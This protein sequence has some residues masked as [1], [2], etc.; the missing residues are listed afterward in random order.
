MAAQGLRA[1]SESHSL[2]FFL[3]FDLDPAVHFIHPNQSYRPLIDVK[4]T[5]KPL[6]FGSCI[7]ISH[8]YRICINSRDPLNREDRDLS[9]SRS[10][11]SAVI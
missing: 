2:T 3:F 8:N 5:T 6:I 4:K 9:T 10:A 11:L 1:S 7:A